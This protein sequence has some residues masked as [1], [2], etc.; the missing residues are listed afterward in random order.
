MAMRHMDLFSHAEM[1]ALTP[2]QRGRFLD[3]FGGCKPHI[4]LL[5]NCAPFLGGRTVEHVEMDGVTSS[6]S[7]I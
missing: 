2:L 7:Q 5:Q 6:L 4:W 1:A 3:R